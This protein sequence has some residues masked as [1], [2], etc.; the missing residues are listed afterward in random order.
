MYTKVTMDLLLKLHR[1]D[2]SVKKAVECGSF[3]DE[4]YFRHKTLFYSILQLVKAHYFFD[5]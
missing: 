5:K 1:K 3:I 4:I 2:Q